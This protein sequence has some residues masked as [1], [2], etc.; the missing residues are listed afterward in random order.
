M[1]S[2]SRKQKFL[3]PAISNKGTRQ[4]LKIAI[5]AWNEQYYENGKFI[6]LG[7]KKISLSQKEIFIALTELMQNRLMLRNYAL[8]KPELR[9]VY[10]NPFQFSFTIWELLNM[11]TPKIKNETEINPIKDSLNIIQKEKTEEDVKAGEKKEIGIKALKYALYRFVDAGFI[12]HLKWRRGKGE[13]GKYDVIINPLLLDFYEI[14][15]DFLNSCK[16]DNNKSKY[17]KRDINT[18]SN[19]TFIKYKTTNLPKSDIYKRQILHTKSNLNKNLQKNMQ[20]NPGNELDFFDNKEINLIDMIIS[21]EKFKKINDNRTLKKKQEQQKQLSGEISKDKQLCG[22]E[23]TIEEIKTDINKMLV[24]Q[25]KTLKF[26]SDSAEKKIQDFLYF[27][28]HTITA[29]YLYF[30]SILF[31]KKKAHLYSPY[32]EESPYFIYTLQAINELAT[33]KI[34]FGACKT[35]FDYENQAKFL[36]NVVFKTKK[37]WIEK[38]V[39]F[40]MEFVHPNRYLS[41]TYKHFK[42]SKAVE[43]YRNKL[44][45][46]NLN[47]KHKHSEKKFTKKQF[48]SALNIVSFLINRDKILPT[49]P[50]FKQFIKVRINEKDGSYICNA[51]YTYPTYK[52][53]QYFI[54]LSKLKVKTV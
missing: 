46:K 32:N 7:S 37:G 39:N 41:G 47:Y 38:R 26:T 40:K 31:D 8:K 42:F 22:D 3:K 27:K 54:K 30:L 29:F 6:R 15:T 9:N 20:V 48:Q 16:S 1:K 14:E 25:K 18:I 43:F 28:K 52:F 19:Y 23:R 35:I 51:Q 4:N 49:D 33:N 17:P 44:I 21:G 5:A 10:R 45:A 2:K 13:K 36:K 53:M 11:I 50:K 34:Y 12:M 24:P